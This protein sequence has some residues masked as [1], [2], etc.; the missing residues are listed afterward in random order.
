MKHATTALGFLVGML[1]SAST[2]LTLGGCPPPPP[3]PPP[4]P[5]AGRPGATC[6]DVCMR[7]QSLGCEEGKPT[8]A[9][10][11]CVEVCGINTHW[12][13]ACLAAVERCEQI[14]SCPAE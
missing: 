4:A 13:K 12:D 1:A 6:Q 8:P 11:T 14:G 10:V 7:W 2:G 5:D 9:G 3:L